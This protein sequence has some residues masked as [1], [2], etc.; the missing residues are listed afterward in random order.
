M[1]H[2]ALETTSPES[3]LIIV[4]LLMF[5]PCFRKNGRNT[6]LLGAWPLWHHRLLG[7]DDP[8]GSFTSWTCP[9]GTEYSSCA[10]KGVI[11]MNASYFVRMRVFSI[12]GP[13]F[14]SVALCLLSLHGSR[15]RVA[16]PEGAS[17]PFRSFTF[18]PKKFKKV[19]F[20]PLCCPKQCPPSS[21]GIKGPGIHLG[22]E[23]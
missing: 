10:N 21:V 1:P 23:R 5:N 20:F 6:A 19:M 22:Y 15:L 18:G 8:D 9:N 2:D 14:I 3:E 12:S 7:I 17:V 16:D 4:Q 13:S 11:K